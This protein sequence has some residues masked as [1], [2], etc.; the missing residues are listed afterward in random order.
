MDKEG[1]SGKY[2]G[3]VCYLNE[4]KRKNNTALVRYHQARELTGWG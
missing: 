2:P 4:P 1:E 3:V